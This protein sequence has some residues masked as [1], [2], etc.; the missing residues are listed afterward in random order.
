MRKIF[1]QAD[2]DDAAAG[3][4]IDNDRIGIIFCLFNCLLNQQFCFRTRDQHAFI[5]FEIQPVKFAMSGNIGVG[6][7]FD[8]PLD[9]GF[10]GFLMP[11]R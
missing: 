3:T 4:D 10:E 9:E 11:F 5:N 1:S 6:F 7:T 8:A 2:S